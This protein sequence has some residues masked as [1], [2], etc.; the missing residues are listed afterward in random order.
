MTA[1]RYRLLDSLDAV[2]ELRDQEASAFAILRQANARTSAKGR[3]YDLVLADR[4]ASVAA[5]IWDDAAP[6]L[7]AIATIRPGTAVKVAFRVG[8]YQGATQLTIHEIRTAEPDDDGFDR[9]RLWGDVPDWIVA[10]SCRTL[11]FDIETVPETGLRELPQTIVKSLTEHAERRE[12]D[13][14][15]VMGLSPFFGRV[16]SLAFGEGECAPEDQHVT[17]LVVPPPDTKTDG[18]PE[19]IRAVSELDLLRAFWALAATAETVVTY[20]GRGFD[21]PF[22]TARSIVHGIPAQV[23]LVSSRWSLRPHLDLFDVLGQQNRGP[24]NLDVVCWALGIESPK[25]AMDGSMV[26]SAWERGKIVDIATYNRHDVIATTAV[27]HRVRDLVL[28]FRKD[29]SQG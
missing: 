10:S 18:W 23:D 25:G 20:N 28:R 22:L 26:A 3:S 24:A 5:K 9:T 14:S 1:K 15:A 21:V 29:W 7:Q 8:S 2:A 4:T 27:Y 11:V 6:A 17:V 16:V 12:M 13:Q 19:W